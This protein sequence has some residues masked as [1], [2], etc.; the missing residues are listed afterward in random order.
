MYL[1]LEKS[2]ILGNHSLTRE[3]TNLLK[4]LIPHMVFPLGPSTVRIQIQSRHPLINCMISHAENAA[5]QRIFE[6][7]HTFSSTPSLKTPLENA[8]EASE[9]PQELAC[10]QSNVD[11]ILSSDGVSAL[12]SGRQETSTSQAAIFRRRSYIH[13]AALCWSLFLIGWNDGSVGP[14]LPA[15]QRSY[16]VTRFIIL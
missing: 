1:S 12:Q 2:S 9:N 10:A 13:F 6:L 5:N 7:H 14:L 11:T 16:N 4:T 15:I 8:S 3:W